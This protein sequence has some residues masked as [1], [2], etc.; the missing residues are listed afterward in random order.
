MNGGILINGESVHDD[1]VVDVL[2]GSNGQDWFLFDADSGNNQ[3]R[4]T[5][6]TSFESQYAEDIEFIN[7][8]GSS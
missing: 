1:G 7:G 3:D 4:I 6:M 5:D 8:S 2:T